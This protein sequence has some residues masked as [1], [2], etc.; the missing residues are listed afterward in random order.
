MAAMSRRLSRM[1]KRERST[2]RSRL[3]STHTFSPTLACRPFGSAF[4]TLHSPTEHPLH[5]D[6]HKGRLKDESDHCL[7]RAGHLAKWSQLL[8]TDAAAVKGSDTV[9]K[10]LPHGNVRVRRAA[11][12][13]VHEHECRDGNPICERNISWAIAVTCQNF[14]RRE[15]AP[16]EISAP[17]PQFAL[18]RPICTK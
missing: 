12:S 14:Q 10:G 18:S 6:D 16:T 13:N 9:N 11:R 2:L 17:A 3:A 15:A 1:A 7:A 8:Q 5:D 4:Q